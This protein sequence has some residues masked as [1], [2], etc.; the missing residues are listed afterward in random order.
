MG[1]THYWRMSKDIPVS[2]WAKIQADAAKLIATS[3]APL[4]YEYDKTDKPPV[5]DENEIRFNG[6]D[7]DGHETFLLKREQKSFEFCKTAS[8]PYDTVVCAVLACAHE[9]AP[10]AI[11]VSSDG[12]GDDWA[13]PLVWAGDVLGREIPLPLSRD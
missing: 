9:H 4:A 13:G 8:K 11:T 5:C 3:P 12:D 6:R 7:E 2:A 1:Y 10:E